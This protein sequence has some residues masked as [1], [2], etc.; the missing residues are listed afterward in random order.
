M[1]PKD[2]TAALPKEPKKTSPPKKAEDKTLMNFIRWLIVISITLVFGLGVLVW[3]IYAKNWQNSFV[4]SL[5]KIIP[6]PAVSLGYRDWIGMKEY[7]ENTQAMKS[8]LESREAA[9]GGGNFDFSTGEGLKRLDIVKKNILNELIKNKI[10]EA[11]ARK[12]GI[13]VSDS[14]ALD[15]AQNIIQRDGKNNENTVQLKVLYGWTVPDFAK[16]TIKSMLYQEKLSAKLIET[17]ELNQVSKQKLAEIEKRIN[18]NEDFEKLAREF[19]ESASR[20]YGGLIPY[21]SEEDAPVEFKNIVFSMKEGETKGPLETGDGW[22]FVKLISKSQTGG[23]EKVEIR[24]ILIKKENFETWLSETK[25]QA[26]I[27]V[28]LGSYYWHTQ[29]GKIYFKDDALNQLEDKVNRD[30]LN[31]KAQEVDFM[32]NVNN[33]ALENKQK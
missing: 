19:S 33:N 18:A 17:G 5:E 32:L 15:A 9:Y 29:M 16:K 27:S 20:Q 11:E 8:F 7:N 1:S 4:N 6:F 30:Y 22:Q 13:E 23:K 2:K 28:F 14:E 25:K 3:G 21:F 31:E 10:I 12:R 26:K 24:N